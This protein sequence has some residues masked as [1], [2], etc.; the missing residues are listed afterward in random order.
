MNYFSGTKTSKK[1]QADKAM[2]QLV[3]RDEI[4]EFVKEWNS[5]VE[6]YYRM[7]M[8]GCID[9]YEVELYNKRMIDYAPHNIT[10]DEELYFQ[11][12]LA[13]SKVRRVVVMHV[14]AYNEFVLLYGYVPRKSE[15]RIR[16][17]K[18]DKWSCISQPSNLS[19]CEKKYIEENTIKVKV[20]IELRKFISE[21]NAFVKKH[22][23]YPSGVSTD[24]EERRL[25]HVWVKFR[26]PDAMTEYEKEYYKNNI[27]T[28][29]KTK[30][31]IDKSLIVKIS[32]INFVKNYNEFV[33]TYGREPRRCGTNPNEVELY[34]Q[35]WRYT[36]MKNLKPVDAEYLTAQGFKVYGYEVDDGFTK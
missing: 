5:F 24:K 6:K 15:G 27:A 23:K 35:K 22:N 11:C 2:E 16:D 17:N 14:R 20:R 21:F 13:R 9:P 4:R 29:T 31:G 26:Q 19:E 28:I 3:V 33:Q 8:Y 32:I 12:Y 34:K 30:T 10:Q 18:F 25:Y 1:M 36:Q 7:P